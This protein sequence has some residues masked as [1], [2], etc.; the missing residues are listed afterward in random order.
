M[1]KGSISIVLLVL[2]AIVILCVFVAVG[3][4]NAM[5]SLD[6]EVNNQFSQIDVQLQR[7]ADLIPNL[8]NTVKGYMAHEEKIINAVTEARTKYTNASSTEEK[9]AAGEEMTNALNNLLVVV[10]NYPDLKASENFINLQDEIAGTEN[11][12]AV[13]RKNYNDAVTKYNKK[14]R[15][16]PGN[17]LSGMFGFESKSNFETEATSREVPTVT[18]E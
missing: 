17:I 8:V 11:R 15:T 14:I 4:Y 18:F 7:R 13:A 1:N 3:Q 5:V 2:L 10:E 6:E 12:V 9:I 16:F